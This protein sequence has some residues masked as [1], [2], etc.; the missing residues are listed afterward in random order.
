[1]KDIKSAQKLK[2]NLKNSSNLNYSVTLPF[3]YSKNL[4]NNN[5]NK[6]TTSIVQTEYLSTSLKG[7]FKKKICF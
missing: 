5:A 7:T 2:S 3:N 1:M 6:S 4:I